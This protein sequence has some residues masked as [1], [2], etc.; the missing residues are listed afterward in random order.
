MATTVWLIRANVDAAFLLTQIVGHVH[1]AQQWQLG[2][3]VFFRPVFQF[4]DLL[5]QQILVR[6]DHHRHGATTVGLEPFADALGI[7]ASSVDHIVTFDVAL[8]GVDDPCVILFLSDA[9]GRAEADD[10]RAQIAGT[11]GHCLRD[12]R[13]VD[14]TVSG[15]PENAH[16]IVGFKEGI[17]FFGFFR[18]PDFHVD[19]LIAAHGTG[20]FK[21]LHPLFGVR[22]TKRT[23]LVVIHRVIDFLSQT[24][25]KLGRV[26]LH[27]HDRP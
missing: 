9:G 14:I 25:I 26:A 13:G 7:V 18:R 17:T 2:A 1:I 12:L 5:G 8:F 21:L 27:V 3:T 22:Q 19:A 10:F 23:C 6:H 4:G 20:A 11:F 16:Q 15:I 24:G